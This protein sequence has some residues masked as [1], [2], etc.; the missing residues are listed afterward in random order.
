MKYIPGQG[1]VNEGSANTDVNKEITSLKE[2][3]K[4]KNAEIKTLKAE[5]KELKKS[6]PNT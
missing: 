2:S 6:T 3:I 1:V 5:I 4:A